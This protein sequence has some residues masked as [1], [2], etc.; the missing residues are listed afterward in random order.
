MERRVSA[1]PDWW[2]TFF[3]GPAL[4]LW[5]AAV[6]A[7]VTRE[8]ADALRSAL[9][10]PPG[11]RILD[12]PCGNGRL[13]LV[14][15]ELGF[16]MSGLDWAEDFVLEAQRSARERGLEIE[17]LQ[18]DMSALPWRAE[19]EGAFCVGNSFSYLTHEG[20]VSF[21]RSVAEALIRGGLFV[22]EYPMVA[23]IALAREPKH[24]W[25]Q[26]GDVL[27]LSEA[28]YDVERSRVD[29]TYTFVRDGKADARK[30]SYQVYTCR[31]LSALLKQAGFS[32]VELWRD[33]EGT[34]FERGAQELFAFA[35]R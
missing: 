9:D 26:F 3:S 14:L 16:R 30:A 6:P 19:F 4:D 23:E 28:T 33:L 1:A 17:F 27:M 25:Y 29:T 34:P 10:L 13:A 7:E 8:Q 32:S 11:A 12:V 5:R 21:L 20:N 22:L 24:D 15:A 35:R 2:K 31:E 18:G